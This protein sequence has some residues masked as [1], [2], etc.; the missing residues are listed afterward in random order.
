MS[1]TYLQLSDALQKYTQNNNPQFVGMI[2]LF[3]ANGQ[4]RIVRDLK[5]LPFIADDEPIFTEG[6]GINGFSKPANWLSTISVKIKRTT[7][8]LVQQNILQERTVEYIQQYNLAEPRDFVPLYYADMDMKIIFVSSMIPLSEE[9]DQIKIFFRYY[10]Q[11]RPLSPATQENLLSNYAPDLL[12][13][14][15]L[16]ETA[17]YLHDDERLQAWSTLYQQTKAAMSEEDIG[18]IQQQKPNTH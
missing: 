10:T 15:C 4:K 12:L 1:L 17:P 2:P 14:S 9:N 7:P 8:T 16:M 5:I 11:D 18:R 3:V 13:Y 6:L